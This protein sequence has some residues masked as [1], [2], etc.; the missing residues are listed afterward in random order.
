MQ[1]RKSTE[2]AHAE[3]SGLA[4]RTFLLGVVVT[5]ANIC[6]A[7]HLDFYCPSPIFS[8]DSNAEHEPWGGGGRGRDMEGGGK[9]MVQVEVRMQ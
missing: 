5:V 2:S 8:P 6:R 3:I 4:K 1:W 7:H 9:A